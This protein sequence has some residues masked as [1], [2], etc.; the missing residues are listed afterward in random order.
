MSESW[1]SKM[2]AWPRTLWLFSLMFGLSYFATNVVGVSTIYARSRHNNASISVS[3]CSSYGN[4]TTPVPNTLAAALATAVAGDTISF[5]CAGSGTASIIV[6]STIS[7]TFNLTLQWQSGQNI[8]LSGNNTIAVISVTGNTTLALNRLAIVQGKAST[9]GGAISIGAGSTVTSTG[10]TFAGN[11]AGTPALTGG[12]GGAI[13]IANGGT[14]TSS[15]DTFTGNTAANGAALANGYGGAIYNYGG[16]VTSTGDTITSNMAANG[17]AVYTTGAYTSTGDTFSSNSATNGGAIYNAS[18]ISSSINRIRGAVP[19]TNHDTKVGTVTL[20]GGTF[21][22]NS[23]TTSGGAIYNDGGATSLTISNAIFNGNTI[24]TSGDGG[25]IYNNGGIFTSTGDT[26]T[27]NT[28]TADG[29]AIYN[30]GGT[31]NTTASNDTFTSN[32]AGSGGAVHSDGGT[33]N[34]TDTSFSTNSATTSGGAITNDGSFVNVTSS[35]F[36]N[37]SAVDGG[38]IYLTNNVAHGTVKNSTF[39]GNVV[40][41]QSAIAG[42]G[43]I[44]V[45]QGILDLVSDTVVGNSITAQGNTF[46]SRGAGLYNRGGTISVLSSILTHNIVNYVNNNGP[47]QYSSNCYST[48]S[49]KGFNIESATECEF[50]KS[51]SNTS[52]PDQQNVTDNQ[53]KLGQL[54][55]N[56]G[57]TLTMALGNGSVAVNRGAAVGDNNCPS[58]DQRGENRV[59]RCDVGAFEFRAPVLHD[60]PKDI[61]IDIATS[62]STSGDITDTTATWTDPTGTL[63]D[64]SD[65]ATV[66]CVPAAGSVFYVGKTP[67]VCTASDAANP[68]TETSAVFYVTVKNTNDAPVLNMPDDDTV[69]ATD[70]KGASVTY[71]VTATDPSFPDDQFVVSCV[72]HGD[73]STTYPTGIDVSATFPMGQTVIDCTATNP[74][75]KSTTKSATVEVND[76]PIVTVPQT[77][78]V[79]ATSA[80]GSAVKFIVTA[81]DAIYPPDQL[82]IRC[83]PDSTSTFPIGTTKVTCTATNPNPDNNINNSSAYFNVVVRDTPTVNLPSWPDQT[84][85]VDA[86]SKDGAAVDLSQYVT[87]SNQYLKDAPAISCWLDNDANKINIYPPAV[88]GPAINIRSHGSFSLPVF[89]ITLD[90][91]GTQV[92]CQATNQPASGPGFTSPIVSFFVK[93]HD[94]LQPTI[95]VSDNITVNATTPKGAVVNY[96]VIVS[97]P[98]Y[99]SGSLIVS[100]WNDADGNITYPTGFSVSATFPIGTT[101]VDCRVSNPSDGVATSNFTVVVQDK[102]Q[103][104]LYLPSMITVHPTSPQG[105]VV[106]YSFKVSDPIFPANQLTKS[107]SPESGT[108]FAIGITIVHCS[109]SNPLGTTTYGTFRI[110]VRDAGDQIADLIRDADALNLQRGV[111][112]QLDTPLNSALSAFNSNRSNTGKV[113]DLLNTFISTVQRLRNKGLTSSQADQLTEKARLIQTVLG[114]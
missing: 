85:V 82:T 40:T 53:L 30:N 24:T 62:P 110:R 6:P 103:P 49:D 76:T 71:S 92:D 58:T 94:T 2:R 113:R 23:A 63:P 75:G 114:G 100:C 43:V 39:T 42:G 50:T 5:A 80:Q 102:L 48:I 101:Q 45:S 15:T 29:G 61:T 90:G 11:L 74:A 4:A 106:N 69:S 19:H 38:A 81:K 35:T 20:A 91:N 47:Q 25:A 98:V 108:T 54:A 17:G 9:S 67:V 72:K 64:S 57:L 32:S 60:V 65:A 22:G 78:K 7:I 96:S 13:Y 95:N 89:P 77:I 3:D 1:K 52:T 93:V 56:G 112:S 84:F 8:A 27:G 16:T 26:F 66:T 97:D 31:T 109:V 104:T 33:F 86:T 12:T 37:N 70:P 107:C 79:D 44:E 21:S 111:Q 68:A 87:A 36:V 55:N 10:D 46:N 83:T 41:T 88:Q 73:N 14:F 34:I 18:S 59:Q 28:A 51:A 105:V 99:P